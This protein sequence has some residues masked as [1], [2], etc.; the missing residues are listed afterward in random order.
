MRCLVA[1]TD[2]KAQE[3]GRTFLWTEGHRNRGPIEFNDPP[4]YQS[5]EAVRVKAQRPTGNVAGA[6]GLGVGLSYEELQ[7]VNNIIVGTPD[8][9]IRKLS[10]VIEKLSPGYIH[11][12]G[13][14]GAMKHE[15]VM[16]SIQLLGTEVIPALHEIQLKPYE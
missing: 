7:G 11:I 16:R 4:G 12:Y 1:D 9:V 2:E 6:G 13:N 15:D 8:T 10:Q 14:E 3:I 5:R